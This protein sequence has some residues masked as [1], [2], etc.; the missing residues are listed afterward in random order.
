MRSAAL[1]ETTESGESEAELAGLEVRDALRSRSFWM[2][3]IAEVL[4]AIAGVG[5]RVH[6]VPLLTGVG[7][8]PTFAAEILG[9]MWMCC[10]FEDGDE[11][12]RKKN[13]A[14]RSQ[15]ARSNSLSMN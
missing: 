6:L 2:I 3:A 10:N 13:W 4:F 1:G 8:S 11:G 7:Y 5:L 15:A 14:A 9:A 12:R